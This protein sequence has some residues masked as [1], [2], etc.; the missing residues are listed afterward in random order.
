MSAYTKVNAD[1]KDYP[2]T[3][4]PITAAGMEQIEQGIADAHTEHIEKAIVDAKGDLIVATAADTVARVAVGANYKILKSDSGQTSGV[5]WASDGVVDVTDYGAVADDS[6][7]NTTAFA[8]AVAALSAS[9]GIVRVP[10]GVYRGSFALTANN[11]VLFQGYGATIRP[12]ANQIAFDIATTGDATAV[13]CEIKGFVIDGSISSGTTTGIKITDCDR[14]RV[15]D[16]RVSSCLVGIHLKVSATGKWVEE[17]ALLS[18]FV[19]DSTTGIKFDGTGTCSFSETVMVDVGVNN[20]TT[21][22]DLIGGAAAV[23]NRSFAAGLVVWISASQTAIKVATNMKGAQWNVGIETDSA[24]ATTGIDIVTGATNCVLWHLVLDFVGTF[25]S[26]VSIAPAGEDLV[27]RQSSSDVYMNGNSTGGSGLRAFQGTES[28]PRVNIAGGF[29]GGG[30]LQL[31]PGSGSPDVNLYRD[32]SGQL[33]T[34]SQFVASGGVTTKTKAGT[35]TDADTAEDV[36]GTIIVDTTANKIWVR[37]GGT[38][39]GVAVA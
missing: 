7:D 30:G 17:V 32:G 1:W 14:V 8:N 26:K 2:D 3:S 10:P 36:D 25:A 23:F 19:A 20:C 39:K 24:S 15:Q 9:G 16:V 11:H 12:L 37:I 38:W 21:G 27:W 34:D 35:P 29:A 4:T 22:L 31:G 13:G 5:K 18:V 33:K 6:T 28:Y